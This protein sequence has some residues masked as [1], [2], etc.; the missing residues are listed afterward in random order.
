MKVHQES[1]LQSWEDKMDILMRNG[2]DWYVATYVDGTYELKH[3]T[4]LSNI[5]QCGQP[6]EDFG[7][8]NLEQC[9]G[10]VDLSDL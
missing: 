5:L 9:W 6:A 1:D 4:Q 3:S 2:I 10:G 8:V 7:I